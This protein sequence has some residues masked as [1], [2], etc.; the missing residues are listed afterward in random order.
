MIRVLQSE[1]IEHIP[2]SPWEDRGNS[3]IYLSMEECLQKAW[4]SYR[5]ELQSVQVPVGLQWK[6]HCERSRLPHIKHSSAKSPGIHILL[7]LVW[8]MNNMY[9]G[10]GKGYPNSSVIKLKIIPE[11]HRKKNQS[12]Q[13]T[14]RSAQRS[15]SWA[16]QTRSLRDSAQLAPLANAHPISYFRYKTLNRHVRKSTW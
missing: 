1:H 16:Q 6:Y 5:E 12:E 11:K 10:G 13:K 15:T 9:G 8:L 2:I 4:N 3:S 7:K 14:G